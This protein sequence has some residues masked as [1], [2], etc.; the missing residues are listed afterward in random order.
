MS[1]TQILNYLKSK[2]IG[3]ILLNSI[4]NDDTLNGNDLDLIEKVLS[5]AT[6][7]VTACGGCSDIDTFRDALKHGASAVAAC[8]LFVFKGSR[9]S[10]LN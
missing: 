8:S 6:V 10:V 7:P 5:N 9:N 4:D 3:E 2:Q 1:L